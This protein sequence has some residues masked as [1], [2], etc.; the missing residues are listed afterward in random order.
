MKLSISAAEFAEL[1]RLAVVA[2]ELGSAQRVLAEAAGGVLAVD[3]WDQQVR[4]QLAAWVAH[5]A[6]EPIEKLLDRLGVAVAPSGQE[7][8]GR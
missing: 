4:A 7:V 5:G 2:H 3:E 6:L 8:I 1:D